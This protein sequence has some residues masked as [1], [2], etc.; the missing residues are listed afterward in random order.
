MWVRTFDRFIRL[1]V[2]FQKVEF[3]GNEEIKKMKRFQAGI[4][5]EPHNPSEFEAEF[6]HFGYLPTTALQTESSPR[7]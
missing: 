4:P 1:F 6:S 2:R 7:H 5:Y 3:E